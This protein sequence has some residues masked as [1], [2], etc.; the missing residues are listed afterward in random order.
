MKT[1]RPRIL[2]VGTLPPPVH[3]SAV[4][5]QQIKDS[6]YISEYFDCDWI[7][8]GTSRSMDEIGK[9]TLAKPFRLLGALGK[10]FWYLLT[11]RFDLCYLAITCHGSGLL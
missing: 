7:N 4:V 11:R 10:E 1:H 9:T 5:S 6:E 8:L 2:F 3:G